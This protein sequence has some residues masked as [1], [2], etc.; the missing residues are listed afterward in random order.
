MT[1]KLPEP[2]FLT[3]GAAAALLGIS[4]SNL[5]KGVAKGTYPAPRALSPR[6]VGWLYTEL[7]AW[8][9]QRP[10]SEL[11]PPANTGAP[12]PRQRTVACKDA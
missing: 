7:L 11:L 3:R 8:A 10:V 4:V 1:P 2:I 6:R 12:K 9:T 5:V